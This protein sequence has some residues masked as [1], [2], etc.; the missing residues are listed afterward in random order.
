MHS[1]VNIISNNRFK[2]QRQLKAR[3]PSPEQ[4][5]RRKQLSAPGLPSIVRDE[6]SHR[7]RPPTYSMADCLMSGLA[8]FSFKSPSLLKFDEQLSEETVMVNLTSLY[9]SI[10]RLVRRFGS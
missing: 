8:V 9:G 4:L 7:K 2:K 3:L 10:K 6:L 5:K 1:V